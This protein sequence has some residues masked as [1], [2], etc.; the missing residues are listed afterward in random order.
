MNSP[1]HPSTQAKNPYK[2]REVRNLSE[3]EWDEL[4]V[5]SPGGGHIFQ[6]YAWAE[7]KKNLGWK[8]IRVVM[9][10][11][12]EVVGVGQF[13]SYNTFPVPGRLMFC[14]KGPW[15]DWGDEDGVRAFFGGVAGIAKGHGAHTVKIEPEVREGGR[16]GEGSA[17]QCRL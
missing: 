3:A 9:E 11:H 8:P 13:L 12:G 10:K 7:F 16:W 17:L 5:R 4:V 6:S 2:V 1:A 15:I 14:P